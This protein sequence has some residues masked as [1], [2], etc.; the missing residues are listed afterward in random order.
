M[1]LDLRT[2]RSKGFRGLGD[3]GV[4]SLIPLASAAITAGAGVGSAFIVSGAQTDVAKIKA[5]TD[6]TIAL[7]QGRIALETARFNAVN[8]SERTAVASQAVSTGGLVVGV[9]LVLT[10]LLGGRS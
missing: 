8:A 6:L 10:L 2:T 4:E 1:A 9:A 5:K 7:D 3:F